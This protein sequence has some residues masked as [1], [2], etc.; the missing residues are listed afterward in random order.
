MFKKGSKYTRKDI[1]WILLPENGRP[2]GGSWDTG[3]VEVDGKLIVFMNIGVPGRTDHNFD[4]HFNEAT[5]TITWFGKP[6]TNSQQPQFKRILAG[7]LELH[8]FARWDNKDPE[9]TYL[10]IG[11]VLSFK[12]GVVTQAGIETVQVELIVDDAEYILAPESIKQGDSAENSSFLLEKHLEDFL[13]EN[14][15]RTD[16]AERYKIYE[17]NGELVGQQFRTE[18]GPLDILALSHDETEFLVVE[19]KRDRA[20]D[21][22][23]GQIYRYMG[24]VAKNL[25]TND[26]TVKGRIIGLRGD[27]KLEDALY[28]TEDITFARYQIDFRLVDGF[29]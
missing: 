27:R 6:N 8:F 22:V 14:W 1:G 12:D 25:C 10:G 17:I 2:K 21:E 7:E 18:T 11:H 19:L 28:L 3:Y 9:F 16:L 5:K 13:V 15:D 29:S 26:Q 23:V 24:W 4:N 20:S